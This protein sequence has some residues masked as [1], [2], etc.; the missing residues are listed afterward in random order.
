MVA[1]EDRYF[2]SIDML[3]LKDLSRFSIKM[4]IKNLLKDGLFLDVF[5]NIGTIE[6]VFSHVGWT[7]YSD[8]I[9]ME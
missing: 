5:S 9:E 2:W 1:S 7:G 8:V 3:I 4:A 6:S